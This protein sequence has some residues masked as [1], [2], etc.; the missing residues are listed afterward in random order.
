MILIRPVLTYVCKT[1]TLSPG[2]LSNAI[3]PIP[4]H[5]P[6][7]L[8]HMSRSDSPHIVSTALKSQNTDDNK[9]ITV[10]KESTPSLFPSN[11]QISLYLPPFARPFFFTEIFFGITFGGGRSIELGEI[12]YRGLVWNTTSGRLQNL[13]QHHLHPWDFILWPSYTE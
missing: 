11:S 6:N 8:P 1:W 13:E 3:G 10:Y 9:H 12:I 7:E 4:Y 5:T 2:D